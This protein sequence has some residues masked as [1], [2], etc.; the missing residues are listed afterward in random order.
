MPIENLYSDSSMDDE[1]KASTSIPEIL[2]ITK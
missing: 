2:S 1:K